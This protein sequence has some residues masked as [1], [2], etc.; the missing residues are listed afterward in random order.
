MGDIILKICVLL[1]CFMGSEC[2]RTRIHEIPVLAGY[3]RD[4][5]SS[6]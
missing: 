2:S 4:K 5:S 3:R 1:S 6:N